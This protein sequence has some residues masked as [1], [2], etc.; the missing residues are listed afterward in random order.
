MMHAPPFF[1]VSGLSGVP[2]SPA[3]PLWE[4]MRTIFSGVRK[5]GQKRPKIAIYGIPENCPPSHSGSRSAA[6]CGTLDTPKTP[7]N[8]YLPLFSLQVRPKKT[9]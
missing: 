4:P 5:N 6:F 3:K 7:K 2:Q 1:Q 8:P 9:E